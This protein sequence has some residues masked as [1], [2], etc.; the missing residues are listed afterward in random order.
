M[1]FSDFERT[2][3]L[4]EKS[5]GL[6]LVEILE[7]SGINTFDRLAFMNS[8]QLLKI[9]S[10]ALDSNNFRNSPRYAD[11]INDCISCANKNLEELSK[12]K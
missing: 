8:D 4:Q 10:R 5:V 3:L 11:A 6:R 9:V 1:K 7:S 2:K 12:I